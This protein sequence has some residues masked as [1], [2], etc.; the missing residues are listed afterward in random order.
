MPHLYNAPMATP[1]TVNNGTQT[2]V[3]IATPA[4]RKAWI[5]ELA[6][7]GKDT[8]GTKVPI[9]VDLVKQTTAGSGGTTVTPVPITDCPAALSTALERPTSEPTTTVTIRGPWYVTS[10][11]GLYILQL[12]LG[13][14]VELPV[15]SRVGLRIITPGAITGVI[16]NLV[17]QE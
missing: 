16:G 13:E 17:F 12:A 8:D 14:E 1:S 5:K 10:V 9:W 6:C 4:S 2:L 11:G 3:Q 15:N 7:S